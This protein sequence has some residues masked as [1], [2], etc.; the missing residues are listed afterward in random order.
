MISTL[1]VSAALPWWQ[2]L[3]GCLHVWSTQQV[4]TH[5]QDAT[6]AQNALAGVHTLQDGTGDR[7]TALG[8]LYVAAKI[9]PQA[10]SPKSFQGKSFDNKSIPHAAYIPKAMYGWARPLSQCIDCCS[11]LLVLVFEGT[12]EVCSGACTCPTRC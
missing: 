2:A 7:T 8:N 4:F 9:S 12:Y 5:V 1:P 10:V 6:V 11:G 3:A